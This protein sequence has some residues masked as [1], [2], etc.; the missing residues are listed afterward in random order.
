MENVPEV[1]GSKNVEHFAEW[2][3]K[4]ESLGYKCYYKCLNAKDFGVPQNRNRCFMVSIL[5]D[6]DYDF[7]QAKPLTVRLKDILEK[8]VDEKYYLSIK[9]FEYIAKREGKYTQICDEETEI[10]QSAITAKGNN[11]WTG[12]FVKDKDI[13]NAIRG[14]GVEASTDTVGILWSNQAKRIEKTIDIARTIMARDYKGFGKFATTGVMEI[15]TPPRQKQPQ[16]ELDTVFPKDL[17][18]E[19]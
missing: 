5:G 15:T 6:Y 11:N 3:A 14:G 18:K 12:N 8:Q 13:S 19:E 2:L 16:S 7:P 17:N 4:L 9:G 1:I 10:A